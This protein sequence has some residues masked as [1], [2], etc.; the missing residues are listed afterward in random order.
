[1]ALGLTLYVVLRPVFG[2]GHQLLVSL[3][4]R[5]IAFV[6]MLPLVRSLVGLGDSDDAVVREVKAAQ[7]GYL[8]PIFA[9]QRLGD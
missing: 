7:R 3:A 1:M 8:E 2:L 9:G 4:A 6:A 5:A